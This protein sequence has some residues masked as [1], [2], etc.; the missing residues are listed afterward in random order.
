[1]DLLSKTF[2]AFAA[3]YWISIMAMIA[4]SVPP[5]NVGPTA[6]MLASI[7]GLIYLNVDLRKF[8]LRSQRKPRKFVAWKNEK[9]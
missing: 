3:V 4:V 7:A 2:L 6:Q 9:V 1:M 5:T 8:I